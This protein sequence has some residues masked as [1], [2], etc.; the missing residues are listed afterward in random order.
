M[1]VT[2]EI[3]DELASALSAHGM[4]TARA[5]RE[6]MALEG[7]RRDW[8][9]EAALRRL[10]GFETRLEVHRFLKEHGVFLHYTL[11]DLQHDIEEARRYPALRD[12]HQP[13]GPRAE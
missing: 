8:L 10:L 11:A 6:A 4:D 12:A 5:V 9:S 3:P 7:Y 1:T 13:T 2:I